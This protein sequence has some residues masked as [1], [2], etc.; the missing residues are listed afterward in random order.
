MKPPLAPRPGAR[1]QRALLAAASL[2]LGC[3]A[4]GT[5]TDA[6]VGLDGAFDGPGVPPPDASQVPDLSAPPPPLSYD[7][8]APPASAPESSLLPAA[9]I[10][11]YTDDIEPF[12]VMPQAKGSPVGNFPTYRGMDGSLQSYTTRKPRMIGRQV[13]AYCVGFLLTGDES[14]LDLARAGTRWLLD[15]ARDTRRGGWYADLDLVGAPYQDNA[16]FAQDMAYTVMGPAAYFYVTRDPEAEAAV[17]AT[18]DLLFDPKTYWDPQGGR[19][20]D[21]MNGDLTMEQWMEQAGSWQLVAQLDPVTAFLLLVQ[22]MLTDPA[23]QAQVLGDLRTL[24]KLIETQFWRDGIFWGSTGNI[25]RYGSNHTDFGHILKSYWA[26]IQIDKRLDD[27][28]FAGFL[29][30]HAAATLTFAFDAPNGRWGK[31]P[32]SASTAS[33]G[34]DWW[35]YAEADQLAATLS[36][37]DPGWIPTV[38]TTSDHFVKDYVDRTRPAREVVSSINRSGGWVYPWPDRDTAKCNEWKNGF[39]S[40]EHALVMTL[41]SHWRQ[42]SPAPLYFALPADKVQAEGAASRP[43]TFLGR[44]AT[45]EDL[46]PLSADAGRRVVRVRFDQIR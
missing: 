11:H 42:A 32:T 22:P 46:R 9:W 19:I 8:T 36:L 23:R 33:Y 7:Y 34:S 20:R 41:F 3:S 15:H 45:V 13:F 40:S 26:L 24:G 4:A 44:A 16:K 17:L 38:A 30:A 39:H 27:H 43:Y 6:G 12:W 21:G 28:P 10:S 29:G 35:A 1:L 5:V 2:L 25:G 37:H 31:A 18:R 14:L